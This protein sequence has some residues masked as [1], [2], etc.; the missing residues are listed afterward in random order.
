[1]ST[2]RTSRIVT[3]RANNEIHHQPPEREK[4][5]TDPLRPR[6]SGSETDEGETHPRRPSPSSVYRAGNLG[7]D[8]QPTTYSVIHSPVDTGRGS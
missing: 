7:C 5:I 1:M 6:G 4:E 3:P 2:P 8:S